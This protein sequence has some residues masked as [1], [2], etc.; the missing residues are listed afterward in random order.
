MP[1][2]TQ[3]FREWRAER[4]GAAKPVARFRGFSRRGL[5]G[6]EPS[7]PDG[8]YPHPSHHAGRRRLDRFG[9]E[10]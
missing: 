5:K 2:F 7:P 3:R 8:G 9:I 10:F 4:R 6:F 1:S